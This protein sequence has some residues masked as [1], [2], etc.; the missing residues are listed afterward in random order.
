MFDKYMGIVDEELFHKLTL[1]FLC[2]SHQSKSWK[3][4]IWKFFNDKKMKKDDKYYVCALMGMLMNIE[5]KETFDAYIKALFVIFCNKSEHEAFLRAFAEVKRIA[6]DLNGMMENVE[7]FDDSEQELLDI[8]ENTTNVI[9]KSSKFYM[10]YKE[11]LDEKTDMIDESE[12]VE[13]KFFNPAYAMDFLK[14]NLAYLPLWARTFTGIERAEYK[15]PTNAYIESY[16]RIIKS[17]LAIDHTLN[18]GSIRMNRYI[19]IIRQRQLEDFSLINNQIRDHHVARKKYTKK[20]EETH[21]SLPALLEE[22]KGKA[23]EKPSVF[24]NSQ[25]VESRAGND[26]KN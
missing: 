18:L 3:D 5:T 1:I 11:L 15:R 26:K 14:K 25:R 7:E 20:G 12:N 19:S 21:E 8:D 17:T 13:N 23:R 9:Y 2:S 22:W 6:G 24:F 10:Y 4:D 16:N